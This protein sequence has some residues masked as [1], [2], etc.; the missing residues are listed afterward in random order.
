MAEACPLK[1][2][3]CGFESRQGYMLDELY[4]QYKADN[5]LDSLRRG[6][7]NFV[8]GTGPLNPK[9]MIVG[10]AP[11]GMENAKKLPFQGKAGKYLNQ[12]LDSLHIDREKIFITNAVKYWPV[13][14]EGHPTTRKPTE[15][16]I[17]YS[18]YYLAKEIEIVKPT[19]IGLAG[20]TALQTM[21]PQ[22]TEINAVHGMLLADKYVPL[23]HPALMGYK[24]LM[25]G[26]IKK[27]YKML[28]EYVK[29]KESNA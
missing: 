25:S 11:G 10:E 23:Y 15:K 19:V 24:P 3:G 27:G 14:G 28:N 29:Q 6:G 2:Q 8:P 16:E 7:I 12:L 18:R 1:G 21:F 5:N 22:F 4:S 13:E 17:A 26:K 9:I 20:W